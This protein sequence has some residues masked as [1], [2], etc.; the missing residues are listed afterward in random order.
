MRAVRVNQSRNVVGLKT[1]T[2]SWKGLKCYV[3]L[4]S[5]AHMSDNDLYATTDTFH[6]QVVMGSIVSIQIL[7]I[8]ALKKYFVTIGTDWFQLGLGNISTI[9]SVLQLVLRGCCKLL[10]F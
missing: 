3:G 1:K 8:A 10:F 7:I 6:V 9:L 4:S 2:L 5:S